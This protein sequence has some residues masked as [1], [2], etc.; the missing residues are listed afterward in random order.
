M[1]EPTALPQD[2]S[3]LRDAILTHYDQF[4]NRVPGPHNAR[5]R[6]CA[7]SA[8]AQASGVDLPLAA[9]DRG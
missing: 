4:S 9:S 6:A 8:A 5:K 2:A 1:A 3:E 7:T